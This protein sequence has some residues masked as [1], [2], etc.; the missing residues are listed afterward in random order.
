MKELN[1]ASFFAGVGGIDLAFEQQGFKT[2]YANEIEPLA[3][4]TYETNFNLKVDNRDIN[5]VKASEIPHF[6]IMLAGF[7]CQAFSLRV[8]DKDL[9]MKKV[10]ALYFLN[11]KE[12]LKQKA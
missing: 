7:P 2:I 9:M 8:I 3:C 12:F 5:N 6:D 4:K 1:C 10:E 11:L